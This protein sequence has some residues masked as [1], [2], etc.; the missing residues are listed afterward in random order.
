M[1]VYRMNKIMVTIGGAFAGFAVIMFIVGVA[2]LIG[3]SNFSKTCESTE[4]V[5]TSMYRTGHG[6]HRRHHVIV[7]YEVD[8]EVYSGDLGYY[9][10]S[11]RRGQYVTVYYDPENPD[12]IMSKPYV[13]CAAIAVFDLIFGTL[14]FGFLIPEFRNKKVINRLAEEG[15]YIVL[16][17]SVER[18]ESAANIKV[19]DVRYMQTDFIYRD[20]YGQEYVF[21]SRAYPPGRCPFNP[22]QDVIVYVDI[23]NNP[24][25][26]YVCTDDRYG[27]E[28][29]GRYWNDDERY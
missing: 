1:D 18:R 10:S 11:M 9:V 8:G 20:G 4:A 5:I 3:W 19:N 28:D 7:E 16:D 23:E 22:W 2:M 14:G 26:Y 6:K 17:G 13:A 25:I 24:K 21:S 12:Y 29:N 15:K 27:P